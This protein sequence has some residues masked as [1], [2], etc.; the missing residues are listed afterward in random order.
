MREIGF[1]IRGDSSSAQRATEVE[2]AS[3]GAASVARRSYAHVCVYATLRKA[4]REG[5]GTRYREVGMKFRRVS[6]V[7]SSGGVGRRGG[8]HAGGGDVGE[9][10]FQA[11][12]WHLAPS[13]LRA[14]LDNVGQCRSS[15]RT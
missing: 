12:V 5:R 2:L 10:L 6:G 13:F 7:G 1:T 8:E 4:C 3:S 14:S 15:A 9:R 11:S